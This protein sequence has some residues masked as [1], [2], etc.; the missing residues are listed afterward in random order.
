VKAAF[1][2]DDLERTV[3]VQGAVFACE[4]DRAL[5][6]FGAGIGEE[7]LIEATSVDERFRQHQARGIVIRGACGDQRLRLRRDRVR[8]ARRRM[9][10][11]V[12]RPSL[13]E[14]E[15]AFARIIPQKGA[16]A[17]HEHGPGARGDIHQRIERVGG[18]GHVELP[19]G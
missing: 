2:G 11:A 3:L 5:I 9:A 7:H 14:V 16:F 6:G 15:I 12:H 8:H 13:D 4:L 18:V 1:E 19:C 17:T 10:E